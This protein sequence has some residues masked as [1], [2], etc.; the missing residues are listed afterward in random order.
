MDTIAGRLWLF[1]RALRHQLLSLCYIFQRVNKI[2]GN[3]WEIC[4]TQLDPEFSVTPESLVDDWTKF[5]IGWSANNKNVNNYTSIPCVPPCATLYPMMWLVN[6][7]SWMVFGEGVV[8]SMWVRRCSL[9]EGFSPPF[10]FFFLFNSFLFCQLW[11]FSPF[12]PFFLPLP[13]FFFF[14]LSIFTQVLKLREVLYQLGT[15][16][17]LNVRRKMK[18]E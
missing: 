11:L 16:F 1:G 3:F 9:V 13:L 4:L 18:Q 10:V 17:F 5:W 6:G 7:L 2:F 14:L 12:P 8:K 15:G